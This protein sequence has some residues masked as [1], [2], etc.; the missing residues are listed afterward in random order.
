MSLI[1]LASGPLRATLNP[2]GG[3]TIA[4]FQLDRAG[5]PATFCAAPIPGLVERGDP[6]G[7]SCFPLVPFFAFV[8]SGRIPFAGRE[9][10][11][12]PN[13]PS[14]RHVRKQAEPL[15]DHVGGPHFG[16]QPGHLGAADL[17]AARSGR[18]EAAD[19]PQER[20]L[21]LAR[22]PEDSEEVAAVNVEVQRLDR[23]DGAVVLRDVA[24]P[25][26]N[27]LGAAGPVR[28]LHGSVSEVLAHGFVV[29]RPENR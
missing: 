14:Y 12:A 2:A 24:Q 19:H 9:W 22:R 10:P 27:R 17:D 25:H 5:Q 6:L 8:R 16:A 18:D 28:W 15:K 29:M 7:A 20:R 13:H 1:E 11:M 3:G 26:Q 23:L 21:A 4:A